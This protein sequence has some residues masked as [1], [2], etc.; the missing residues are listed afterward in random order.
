MEWPGRPALGVG[1]LVVLPIKIWRHRHA[2]PAF[3]LAIEASLPP[4]E[5]R[6]LF[7]PF[8]LDAGYFSARCQASAEV[9]HPFP[10]TGNI[11]TARRWIRAVSELP[12]HR[13]IRAR[14][15]FG[16]RL[17][18][19]FLFRAEFQGSF[20]PCR[21]LTI[22]RVVVSIAISGPFRPGYILD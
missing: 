18:E 21:P 9:G 17:T 13:W 4:V 11:G 6:S 15:F 2:D 20:R 1:R 14:C 10:R 8:L 12:V 5:L 3:A 16:L 22:P 7:R 19:A